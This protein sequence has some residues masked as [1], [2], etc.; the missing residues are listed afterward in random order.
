MTISFRTRLFVSA[1]LIVACVLLLVVGLG[2]SRILAFDVERLDERLCMEARRLL[3]PPAQGGL[4]PT[5]FAGGLI[6]ALL[7]CRLHQAE[8]VSLWGR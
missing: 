7:L 8:P 6:A 5:R 2:W 1:T 3:M 4:G